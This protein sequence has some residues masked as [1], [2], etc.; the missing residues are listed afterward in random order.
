MADIVDTATACAEKLRSLR[1]QL[2]SGPSG[3]FLSSLLT[4]ISLLAVCRSGVGTVRHW[5][6]ACSLIISH[7]VVIMHPYSAAIEWLENIRGTSHFGGSTYPSLDMGDTPIMPGIYLLRQLTGRWCRARQL[8]CA[9]FDAL[10]HV[11]WAAVS[12]RNSH[13]HGCTVLLAPMAVLQARIVGAPQSRWR[14]QVFRV[15]FATARFNAGRGTSG[16]SVGAVVLEVR[17]VT[18]LR[19]NEQPVECV[20]PRPPWDRRHAIQ[21]TR[22]DIYPITP[23]C[24]AG[25]DVCPEASKDGH[26]EEREAE[27]MSNLLWLHVAHTVQIH[28][29]TLKRHFLRNGVPATGGS[30]V[31]L[32]IPRL[33]TASL[34]ASSVAGTPGGI[35]GRRK[36]SRSPLEFG[37]LL[38]R[39]TER[40]GMLHER[41]TGGYR[42]S[43]FVSNLDTRWP[44]FPVKQISREILLL[45]LLSF[46]KVSS[47]SQRRFGDGNAGDVAD[48]NLP[49]VLKINP[50]PLENMVHLLAK[51]SL[52]DAQSAQHSQPSRTYY[53]IPH[54]LPRLYVPVIHLRLTSLDVALRRACKV[55]RTTAAGLPLVMRMVLMSAKILRIDV[56]TE[57]ETWQN[58]HPG[59]NRPPNERVR[60]AGVLTCQQCQISQ[61][62]VPSG[63]SL[64]YNPAASP[65]RP[66]GITC[67]GTV[68]PCRLS[69]S[70]NLSLT[71]FKATHSRFLRVFCR[72]GKL[73]EEWW[74][75]S[76]ASQK[77]GRNGTHRGLAPNPKSGSSTGL[78]DHV[79]CE[80]DRDRRVIGRRE[81]EVLGTGRGDQGE[82]VVEG[83]Q[84]KL[85]PVPATQQQPRR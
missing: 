5:A 33:C 83:G 32:Y 6:V 72:S 63:D 65:R 48:R 79:V 59:E 13:F 10:D 18:L 21:A 57:V 54:K 62:N 39:P 60:A 50:V 78:D 27:E 24:H 16:W 15:Q 56:P 17:R 52:R 29:W 35:S 53:R 9:L 38:G 14:I 77:S 85:W 4:G 51:W 30:S 3:V 31:L 66:Q 68:K 55:H 22:W 7:P 12:F 37:T 74:R 42:P 26:V 40:R 1:S 43:P 70:N 41:L 2:P 25:S 20:S 61:R 64:R 71:F 34:P 8:C 36:F 11:V 82:K 76:T 75:R 58:L 23:I 80:V 46:D 47:W 84:V 67:C 28:V 45:F 73:T 19:Y 49:S 69:M 44:C 81:T